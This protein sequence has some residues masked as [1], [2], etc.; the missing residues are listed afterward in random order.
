MFFLACS[1]SASIKNLF[2][3]ICF[4]SFSVFF[5]CFFLLKIRFATYAATRWTNFSKSK[6]FGDF[7]VKII[8]KI[9]HSFNICFVLFSLQSFWFF[10]F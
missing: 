7:I 6:I 4:K 8:L 5:G 9:S 1:N 10:L 2:C 3:S